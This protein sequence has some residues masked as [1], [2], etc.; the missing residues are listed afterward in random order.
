MTP[1]PGVCQAKPN[2]GTEKVLQSQL[3]LTPGG[4]VIHFVRCGYGGAAQT[5]VDLTVKSGPSPPGIT[6]K[7]LLLEPAE[8]AVSVSDCGC[9]GRGFGKKRRW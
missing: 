6:G 5:V 2:W 3:K 8:A 1:A 9:W 7:I 4:K